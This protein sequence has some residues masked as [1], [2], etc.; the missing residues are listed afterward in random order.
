[1]T[2]AIEKLINKFRQLPGVGRKMAQKYAYAVL[3][4]EEAEVQAFVDA[5]TDA[6]R[7]T[8]FCSVC[9]TFADSS[10]CSICS[11][12]DRG[13]ICVVAEPKDVIAM[14][15]VRGYRGVYHVL[16]GTINPLMGRS[17]DNI[18]LKE[19][20]ARINAGGVTEIIIATNPDVE[21]DATAMYISRLI[22]PL[23][24]RVTRLAQGISIGSDLEFTD[25][26]TLTRS[27]N[28]RIEY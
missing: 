8:C 26:A 4:M 28:N 9:G 5:V 25:E 13:T 14:E 23:G 1:M 22:K 17:P 16:H 20:L 19:L 7:T 18:R 6:K 3:N 21:G 24:V 12:R 27:L 15:R 10:V 2:E 11:S